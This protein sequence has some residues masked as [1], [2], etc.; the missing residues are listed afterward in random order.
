[1]DRAVES[2]E[3]YTP[4]ETVRGGRGRPFAAA[5]D[6]I[7]AAALDEAERYAAAQNSFA[8]IVARDGRIVR[9][10][11]WAGFG[12]ASRFS[13]ASMHKTVMALAF[14][15]AVARGRIGLDDPVERWLPEWAGDPRGRITIRQL[16]QMASGLA[17]P[18]YSPA[19]TSPG[20]A[21]MFGSDIGRVALGLPAETAPGADFAY[22]NGNAQLAGMALERATGVR[23]ADWLSR[24]VW[25]PIGAGDAAVWLDRPGGAPHFFCCLQATARD[26]LR[27][28]E[29]IR[30]GGRAGGRQ[31][32]PAG[33]IGAMA[34]PSPANPNYGLQLWLGSP[35]APARRYSRSSPVTVPAKEP[36]DA[37][38]VVFLDGAGGQRV[39]VVPSA[40]L[41]VVR[42]GK[43]APAW[44]DSAMI[45]MLLRGLAR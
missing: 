29:L 12:P 28:G 27:V 17:V 45:N 6:A 43:A 5:P 13:T 35:H 22:A 9:E 7:P 34:T 3:L 40:G 31:V 42:I 44:D 10:R 16:L 24:T 1:M 19:P 41:T 37:S 23:Y 11:Y 2:P 33:W 21:M 32:V 18:P 14:G 38:D 25:R 8:L 36:F 20:M 15:P 30:N 26:W 4:A 39:Y